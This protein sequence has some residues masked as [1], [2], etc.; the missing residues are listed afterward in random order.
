MI[1]NPVKFF[2]QPNIIRQRELNNRNFSIISSNCV[3]GLIY[4]ELNQRFLSP[5]INLDIQPHDFLKLVTN[6][7]YYLTEAELVEISNSGYPYPVGQ[8]GAGTQ[9][10]RLFFI[11]YADFQTAKLKWQE[12]SQRVNYNNLY[13]I[14][15]DCDGTSLA[16]LQR[17]DQL[18]NSHKV[19]LTG[20]PYPEID[21]AF[22]ITNCNDQGRLADWY[23]SDNYLGKRKFE[24]FN[25]VDFLNQ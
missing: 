19:I 23:L 3:A 22:C 25:Y 24:Q 9:A 14:L 11:H 12:R 10:I 21:S 2:E 8:L 16:D 15:A 6:L 13:F 7:R 18:T 20:Q 1:N 17:F 4:H 5:T